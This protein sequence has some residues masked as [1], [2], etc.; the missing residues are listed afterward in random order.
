M[1]ITKFP[2]DDDGEEVTQLGLLMSNLDFMKVGMWPFID[3]VFIMKPPK[4][5]QLGIGWISPKPVQVS[6]YM[7]CIVISG[8]NRRARNMVWQA[9]CGMCAYVY[10]I[11]HICLL[12]YLDVHPLQ[13]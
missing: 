13:R 4:Q 1:N 8:D 3:Q 2:L 5:L 11:V 9:I 6:R 7:A 12:D 10:K